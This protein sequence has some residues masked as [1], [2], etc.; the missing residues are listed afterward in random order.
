M[1]SRLY[2]RTTGLRERDDLFITSVLRSTPDRG[3]TG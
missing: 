2:S 1:T 3:K